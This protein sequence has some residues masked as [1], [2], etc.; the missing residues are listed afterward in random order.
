VP[1][2][3]NRLILFLIIIVAL[4]ATVVWLLARGPGAGRT[5][6]VSFVSSSASLATPSP[7]LSPGQVV[8]IVMEAMQH[9]DRPSTDAGILTAFNFASPGNKRQTGPIER[10]VKMVKAPTYKPMLDFRGIE[11]GPLTIEGDAAQQL[12]T[13][14]DVADRPA[15]YVFTLTRQSD[16]RYKGCWMTD[17]VMRVPPQR[18]SAATTQSSTHPTT[19]R[20]DG[21]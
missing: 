15:S 11:Y 20:G 12:V 14:L 6:G 3:K 7:D 13:L 9:N 18:A 4:A 1:R 17:G 10:F 19:T 21:T 8:R 2:V 5:G 16:G